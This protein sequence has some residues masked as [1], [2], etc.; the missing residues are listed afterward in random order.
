[1][2]TAL[3]AIRAAAGR[4]GIYVVVGAPWL[5]GRGRYNS[6][7]AVGPSGDLLTRYDQINVVRPELFEGGRSTARM[8]FAVDGVPAFVTIGADAHWTELAELASYRGAQLQFHLSYH[9][10]T[11]P[12]GQILQKQRQILLV[13]FGTFSAVVNAADPSGLAAPSA[14]AAGGSMICRQGTSGHNKPDP[15]GFDLYLPY[16]ASVIRQAGCG[17]EALVATQRVD[18]L[19]TRYERYNTLRKERGWYGWIDRGMRLIRAGTD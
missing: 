4:F 13:S 2:E 17:P 9:T 19:N 14:P 7:F 5:T 12:D 8:W 11:S 16:H 15:G 10:D 18:S 3:S 6:A 1:L